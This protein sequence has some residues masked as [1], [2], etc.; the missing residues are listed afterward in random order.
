MTRIAVFGA[1]AIGCWV[2]GM[3]AAGGAEV[4]LI[5]RARVV[6]ELAGGLRVSD[7]D[8]GDRRVTVHTATDAGAAATA[9]FVLVTVKSAATA[10]AAR[11]LAGVG[12]TVVS[13]QNG[14]RN[15]DALRAQLPHVLAG[16]VPFNIVRRGPGWYHR[17]S[18]GLILIEKSARSGPL[19]LLAP[20]S[21]IAA[22][23]NMPAVQWSKLLMN[24]NNAINALSGVPLA[25]QLAQRAYRRCLAAAQREALE[26]VR[27]ARIELARVTPIPPGWMPRLLDLPDAVFLRLARRVVAIDPLA[28]SSMWEDLEA[29]RTTEID[30]IQGEIVALAERLHRRAP[31]NAAL[32]ALVRAAEAGGRRDYRGDELLTALRS[33]RLAPA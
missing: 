1:G 30:Y 31:V 7:L 28:R 14:V 23:T 15:V 10:E 13:L 20:P 21:L 11:T 27:A 33:A 4:T 6:D 24:L 8:G 2:G 25:E 12:G 5:S 32:V 9:D 3:L 18:A 26:L 16:M 17:G 19:L 29:K 22:R